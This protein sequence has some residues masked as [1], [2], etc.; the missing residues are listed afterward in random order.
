MLNLEKCSQQELMI[1]HNLQTRIKPVH[2]HRIPSTNLEEL[3]EKNRT[4]EKEIQFICKQ[5]IRS[6]FAV[7]EDFHFSRQ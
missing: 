4:L 1:R 3:E 7:Q 2:K 5:V 6:V